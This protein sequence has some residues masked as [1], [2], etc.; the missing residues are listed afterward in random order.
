[1]VQAGLELEGTPASVSLVRI[2]R[3][4]QPHL[5]P[6]FIPP[7]FPSAPTEVKVFIF[8]FNFCFYV[9]FC[10]VFEIGSYC[11]DLVRLEF[12]IQTRLASNS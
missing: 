12:T 6:I 7:L 5:A 1:M 11:V 3:Q 2:Y 4:A 8:N 9:F 10:F